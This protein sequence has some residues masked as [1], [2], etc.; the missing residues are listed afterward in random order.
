MYSAAK[1]GVLGL[2]RSTFFTC[3]AHGIRT[4]LICPWFTDTAIIEPLTRMALIGLP[5]CEMTECADRATHR[6]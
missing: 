2:A 1:H 4:T 5:F 3:Q 6:H